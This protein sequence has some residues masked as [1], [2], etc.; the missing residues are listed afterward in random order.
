MKRLFTL[1]IATVCLTLSS[2]TVFGQGTKDA[3]QPGSKFTYGLS[4][5]DD[6]DFTWWV[7]SDVAGL[8][9]LVYGTDYTITGYGAAHPSG[10]AN[11]KGVEITWGNNLAA[12]ATPL[13]V[14]VEADIAGCTN[15]RY[16]TVTPAND[17]DLA[18]LNVTGAGTP[19]T[20]DGTDNVS[21]NHCPEFGGSFSSN[22]GAYNAGVTQVQV[23]IDRSSSLA[24]W[25]FDL[26]VSG[27]GVVASN[28]AYTTDGTSA[29]GAG[30]TIS[31]SDDANYVLVTFDVANIPGTA[32]SITCAVTGG[33]DTNGATDTVN[34]TNVTHVLKVMPVIGSFN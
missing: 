13:Y 15:T 29:S 31:A 12:L 28:F 17:L 19:A 16:Y 11:L 7:A 1:L 9:K 30:A 34:P 23:R 33:A 20:S 8:T 27:A 25:S 3:P 22:N 10:I 4:S 26:A 5:A 32:L 21:G 24:A 2:A 18:L 14:F 6:G